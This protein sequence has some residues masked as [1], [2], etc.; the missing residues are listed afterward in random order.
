MFNPDDTTPGGANFSGQDPWGN[1]G[2][3]GGPMTDP[4]WAQF[5]DMVNKAVGK[6]GHIT[7]APG[8]NAS[9]AP[10]KTDPYKMDPFPASL[11]AINN[12]WG[13]G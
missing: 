5:F 10:G 3:P 11:G 8:L 7:G 13:L 12:P 9:P 2:T 6:K 1:Q 4:K